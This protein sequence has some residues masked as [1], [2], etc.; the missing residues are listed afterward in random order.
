MTIQCQKHIL[1]SIVDGGPFLCRSGSKKL[2][3]KIEYKLIMK[4]LPCRFFFTL[5]GCSLVV[6]G[7]TDKILGVVVRVMISFP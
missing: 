2:T 6:N 1:C 4:K 5:Q 3:T 7:E